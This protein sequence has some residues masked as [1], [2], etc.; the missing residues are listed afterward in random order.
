[1]G[2]PCRG[3]KIQNPSWIMEAPNQQQNLARFGE[4]VLADHE[5][6]DRL[7]A[8]ANDE[9]FIALAIRLGGERGC[10]FTA[11]AVA[12]ALREQRRAGLERWV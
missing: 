4:W 7:R 9:D 12:T 5:L 1:M 6:H 11:S 8:A 10:V 3:V 2:L